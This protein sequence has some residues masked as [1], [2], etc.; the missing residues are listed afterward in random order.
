MTPAHR[1]LIALVSRLVR[2]D[3]FPPSRAVE[4]SW[5]AAASS[6]QRV[7]SEQSPYGLLGHS[8][9]YTT[10]SRWW[11]AISCASLG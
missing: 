6:S 3:L 11:V 1:L 10:S 7:P 9:M 4:L 5:A 2:A 8:G